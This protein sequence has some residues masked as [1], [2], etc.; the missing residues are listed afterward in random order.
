[1]R[2][3][4][5]STGTKYVATCYGGGGVLLRFDSSIVFV[6]CVISKCLLEMS[7]CYGILLN[8]N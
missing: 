7:V 5:L 4:N 6:Q 3:G 1:M 8:I 2:A